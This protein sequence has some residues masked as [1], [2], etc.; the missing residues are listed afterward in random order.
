MKKFKSINTKELYH[1]S[2]GVSVMPVPMI[3]SKKI[4]NWIIKRF[5]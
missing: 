4:V 1:I 2:G 3:V 5:Q